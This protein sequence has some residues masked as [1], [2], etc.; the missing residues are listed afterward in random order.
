MAF[1]RIQPP[2]LS[3]V[4]SPSAEVLWHAE[5]LLPAAHISPNEA[6]PD[7]FIFHFSNNIS[8][9]FSQVYNNNIFILFNHFLN[10]MFNETLT[11]TVVNGISFNN[12][13]NVYYLCLLMRPHTQNPKI[14]KSLPPLNYHFGTE[15]PL[16]NMAASYLH[17]LQNYSVICGAFFFCTLFNDAFSTADTI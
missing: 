15:V 4:L 1:C 6:A 11:Y 13:S 7:K 5:C 12:S 16:S 10:K 2:V 17:K 9:S 3:T 14:R 8:N